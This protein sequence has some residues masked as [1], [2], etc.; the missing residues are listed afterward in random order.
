MGE[1]ITLMVFVFIGL[2]LYSSMA[3]ADHLLHYEEVARNNMIEIYQQEKEAFNSGSS[4]IP[5]DKVVERCPG[6][7]SLKRIKEDKNGKSVLYGD[8][9][10]IYFFKLE[11]ELNSVD[12]Y[13]TGESVQAPSGYKLM[14]WPKV[15][16]TTGELAYYVDQQGF[17][18]MSINPYAQYDGIIKNLPPDLKTPAEFID[19]RNEEPISNLWEIVPL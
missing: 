17:L 4:Y 13:M 6:L 15:Y 18:A 5:L 11:F 19:R 7:Q 3:D 14:A 16:A 8:D 10:Y 1:I 9:N 2:Y 12:N